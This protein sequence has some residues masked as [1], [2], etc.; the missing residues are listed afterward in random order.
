MTKKKSKSIGIVSLK[1]AYEK[2]LSQ[3]PSIINNKSTSNTNFKGVKID[4]DFIMDSLIKI[5]SYN[6][7]CNKTENNHIQNDL[8]F[9]LGGLNLQVARRF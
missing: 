3:K 9:D 6:T 7:E 5:D 8:D 2:A 1:E 4:S